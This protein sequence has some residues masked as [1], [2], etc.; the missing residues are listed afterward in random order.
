MSWQK[1]NQDLG[2]ESYTFYDNK[3]KSYTSMAHHYSENPYDIDLS[4]RV[5]ACAGGGK[6]SFSVF[7]Y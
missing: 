6:Q 3:D 5:P 7:Y 2:D 4:F 1:Q